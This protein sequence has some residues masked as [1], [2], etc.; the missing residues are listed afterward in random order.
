[1]SMSNSADHGDD[2]LL[3]FCPGRGEFTNEEIITFKGKPNGTTCEF[4]VY[5]T[6]T[7]DDVAVPFPET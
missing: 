6:Q 4:D 3:I 1:M 2:A 7:K 5:D